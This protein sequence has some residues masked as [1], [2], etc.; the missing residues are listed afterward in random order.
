MFKN[1]LKGQ[2]VVNPSIDNQTFVICSGLIIDSG[3]QGGPGYSNGENIAFTICSS[4]PGNQVTVTFQTFALS[5]LDTNP[6]PN[7]NNADRMYVFDGPNTS[8]NSLGNYGGN[9]L[10]GVVIQATPQNTSG[11]LTF[12]FVSN[13]IGTGS[14]AASIS[15][16]IPNA[17]CTD[18]LACNYNASASEDNGSCQ[19]PSQSYLTC[20]GNCLN[21]QDLDGVCDEIQY[22]GIHS[23]PQAI[24]Y[25]AALRNA[26]GFPLN[27][28]AIQVRL[29][30]TQDSISGIPEYV[31]MHEVETNNLGLFSV[32]IGQGM[33]IT[34]DFGEIDW[35]EGN[36]F[37]SVEFNT[38][39]DF[40]LIGTQQLI[41]VPY[42]QHSRSSST[43]KNHSL[44]VFEDNSQAISGGL[45]AGDLY[46]TS[47]G[48]LKIVF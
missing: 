3:G 34:G 15:C 8:A 36:K 28:Q 6:N 26:Q 32:F 4:N 19:Y 14:Y 39:V 47:N 18:S 29:M 40:Q 21:D 44:P 35:V 27:N 23:V 41:S 37:L 7:Q 11:C 38:G 42:A 9:E 1:Q 33:S 2:L 24:S 46:R 31:E 16:I 25:Q 20:E 22:S 13:D 10:Q 48:D 17:G 5:N 45:A 30:I 12:Q 43:I